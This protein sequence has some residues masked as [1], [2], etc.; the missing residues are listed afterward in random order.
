[1]VCVSNFQGYEPRAS[2]VQNRNLLTNLNH[3]VQQIPTVVFAI[4]N[5]D[6]SRQKTGQVVVSAKNGAVTISGSLVTNVHQ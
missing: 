6:R 2:G 1:M 3:S 5:S 4:P